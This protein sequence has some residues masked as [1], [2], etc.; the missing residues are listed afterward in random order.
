[1]TAI[2]LACERRGVMRDYAG[3][4]VGKRRNL[5]VCRW[6][7]ERIAP[8][9]MF[10]LSFKDGDRDVTEMELVEELERVLLGISPARAYLMASKVCEERE[11]VRHEIAGKIAYILTRKFTVSRVDRSAEMTR[12]SSGGSGKWWETGQMAP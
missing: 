4:S 5:R 8:Q 6:I 10:P 11:S 9:Y 1:M 7:A 3:W 12:R 2:S